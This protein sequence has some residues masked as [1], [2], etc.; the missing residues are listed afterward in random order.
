MTKIRNDQQTLPELLALHPILGSANEASIELLI[1]HALPCSFERGGRIYD[2]GESANRCLLIESGEICL[3][4]YT[5]QGEEYVRNH[6]VAGSLVALPV[7]F[8]EH[9]CYPA[10]AK[11]TSRVK[12]YWLSRKALNDACHQ[13]GPLSLAC[14]RYTSE[15]LRQSLIK[16]YSLATT[17]CSHRLAEY[18]LRL[19]AIQNKSDLEL[20]LKIGQLAANLGMRG[21]TLSRVL[22]NWRR[23]GL[24]SGRGNRV[25]ILDL[26]S[27][28]LLGDPQTT[29]TR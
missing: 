22:A 24:I 7:M 14:L 23:Q 19:H 15:M 12:G 8:M 4:C 3:V 28:R 27:L 16:S 29:Q 26:E 10:N 18:V 25:T 17:D 5:E 11:A 2:E 6:F 21:E 1:T 9:G 13:D 20:P